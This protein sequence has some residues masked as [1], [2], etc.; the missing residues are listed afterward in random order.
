MHQ[1]VV[2]GER[3][4]LVGRAATTAGRCVPRGPRPRARRTA[5]GALRPVPTAVPPMASSC[6]GGSAAR[7]APCAAASSCA[8]QPGDLL[9]QRQR[10]R[11]LQV[12]A[13]DLDDVG[14]GRRTWPRACDAA[15]AAPAAGRRDDT[16][17][18]RHVHRGREDVVGR[19]AEVDV[20][21]GMDAAARPRSP[22]SSSRGAVGQHLVHVHVGLRA[23]AGLPH[24][25]AGTRRR[26]APRQ[27][28]VGGTRRWRRPCAASSRPSVAVD[29]RR[30]ALDLAPARSSSAAGMR[31]LEMRKCASERCV[32]APHR[33]SAGTST[34]PKASCSMRVV[35]IGSPRIPSAA[36]LVH[37]HQG[38]RGSR[39]SIAHR[40]PGAIQSSEANRSSRLASARGVALKPNTASGWIR[41]WHGGASGKAPA[42]STASAPAAVRRPGLTAGPAPIKVISL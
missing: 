34:S 21:V 2:R 3:R 38:T 32:C 29:A 37:P 11:V 9:A 1:R 30:G 15:R 4:E 18:G 22:P 42:A 8:T 10:R 31:S 16:Q 25:R 28:L 41:G 26:G 20:V 5:A 6:S 7:D 35:A 27:H 13:A 33:P 39:Q 19:L 40:S 12:G 23:G 36:S 24:R 17:C 14:E